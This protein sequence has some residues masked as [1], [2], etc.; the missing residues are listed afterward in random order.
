MFLR[1]LDLLPGMAGLLLTGA[2]ALLALVDFVRYRRTVRENLGYLAVLGLACLALYAGVYLAFPSGLVENMPLWIVLGGAVVGPV[3]VFVFGCVGIASCAELGIADMPLL[4]AAFEG[5]AIPEHFFGRRHAFDTGR[6]VVVASALALVASSL[7]GMEL[8]NPFEEMWV[9]HF[10]GADPVLAGA[11]LLALT[12][13]GT[14]V[15]CRLGLQN[16][17]AHLLKLGP[18]RYWIAV[19]IAAVVWAGIPFKLDAASWFAFAVRMPVGIGLGALFKRYGFETSLAA[20]GTFVAA[21]HLLK[22]YVEVLEVV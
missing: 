1:N 4:R 7:A 12:V 17:L 8:T 16:W 10:M 22:E 11:V 19:V 5:K 2:L 9:F 20:H 15:F 21:Y 3:L 18:E 6:F 14:E 13:L